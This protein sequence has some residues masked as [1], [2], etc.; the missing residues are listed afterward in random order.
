MFLVCLHVWVLTVV[1][2]EV[3]MIARLHEMVFVI[4][5]VVPVEE[6]DALVVACVDAALLLLLPLLFGVE[7]EDLVVE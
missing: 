4:E 5:M 2:V 6:V 1:V 7:A 3:A